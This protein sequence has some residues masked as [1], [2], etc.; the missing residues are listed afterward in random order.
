MIDGRTVSLRS[1]LPVGKYELLER[2][3]LAKKSE[4]R[5]MLCLG[6]SS[7][8]STSVRCLK[9]G[10]DQTSVRSTRAGSSNPSLQTS[11][12]STTFRCSR[13]PVL[14]RGE[15]GEVVQPVPWCRSE[16]V[17]SSRLASC[18]GSSLTQQL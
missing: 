4:W 8:R 3:R 15:S 7:M 11:Y 2:A 16:A 17:G 5:H 14:A 6:Y 13:S 1:R 12:G 10:I 18:R 9:A